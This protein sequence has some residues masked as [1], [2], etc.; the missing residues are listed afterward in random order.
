MVCIY[1]IKNCDT[2]KKAM[3]WLDEA[4]VAY[5]FH[6]YRVEGIESEQLAAWCGKVGWE[7]LLNRRGTTWRRLDE[8]DKQGLDEARAIELMIEH[9]AMI[10]RPVLEYAGGIEVG[11]SPARYEALFH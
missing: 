6:D 9:P 3:R 8:A 4:G 2:M 5:T 10:K 7:A 11:F 1:G